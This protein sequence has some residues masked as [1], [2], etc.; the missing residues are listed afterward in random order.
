MPSSSL[1]GRVDLMAPSTPGVL[2]ES[3][4]AA[5]SKQL[6]DDCASPRVRSNGPDHKH[7]SRGQVGHR[8]PWVLINRI[9]VESP[10]E[11]DRVVEAF[12][13]RAGKVDQQP[14]F[15]GIEVWRKEDGKEV[16]VS[17]RWRTKEDFQNWI[18]GPAF[19]QAHERAKGSP[20]QAA[21]SVYEVVI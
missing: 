19:R 14:G 15:L 1:K 17:T 5:R 12:R 7:I 4:S 21:G 6:P 18:N 2:T 9:S 3:E 10:T 11:A 20:G 16:M 13:H 8:M